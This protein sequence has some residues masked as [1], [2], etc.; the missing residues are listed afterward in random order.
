MTTKIYPLAVTPLEKHVARWI[1]TRAKEYTGDNPTLGVLEDLSHGCSSGIV[2]HLIYTSDCIRFYRRFMGEIDAMH[3]EAIRECGADF[4]LNPWD[5]D[6]PLA[7][8]DMNKNTLAWF[9][10]EETAFNLARR[11]ELDF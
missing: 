5:D 3:S 8:E 10:F 7:R 9:G 2:N 1:D 11:A 4:K 6:D